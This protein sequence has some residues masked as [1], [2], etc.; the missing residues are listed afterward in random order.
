MEYTQAADITIPCQPE[1]GGAVFAHSNLDD[2]ESKQPR[3][4]R[5]DDEEEQQLHSVG[6]ISVFFFQLLLP[7]GTR[8]VWNSSWRAT[9]TAIDE[10]TT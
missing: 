5:G 9:T 8:L 3:G 6:R 7:V 1:W 4:V 10:G 2:E